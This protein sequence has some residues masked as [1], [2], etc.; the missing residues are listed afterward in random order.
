ML[1]LSQDVRTL[2]FLQ[3]PDDKREWF[4]VFN[5]PDGFRGKARK[6]AITFSNISLVNT[7]LTSLDHSPKTSLRI[8]I[9]EESKVIEGLTA[10]PLVTRSAKVLMKG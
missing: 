7:I 5:T 3:D 10:F 1:R 2:E 6:G 8:R 9:G 4:I